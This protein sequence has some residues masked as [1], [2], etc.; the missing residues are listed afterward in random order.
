MSKAPKPT[1]ADTERL[2]ALVD[3]ELSPHIDVWFQFQREIIAACD[4][5]DEFPDDIDR[6]TAEYAEACFDLTQRNSSRVYAALKTDELRADFL[7]AMTYSFALAMCT[8]HL[9]I[10]SGNKK[11]REAGKKRGKGNQGTTPYPLA[12]K[13]AE[14]LFSQMGDTDKRSLTA[15]AKAIGAKISEEHAKARVDEPTPSPDTIYNW[16]KNR[17]G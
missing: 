9:D 8:H 1:K 2:K 13:R 7:N 17:F 11:R 5:K 6:E 15:K 3:G 4:L 10:H 14:E 12:K 16:L